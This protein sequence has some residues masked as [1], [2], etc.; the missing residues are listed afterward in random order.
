MKGPIYIVKLTKEA[1]QK[2]N[3]KKIRSEVDKILQ[4][5]LG[6]AARK[7]AWNTSVFESS[8]VQELG[9]YTI[10]RKVSFQRV[11]G[12][13]KVEE[14]QWSRVY[15][16][17]LKVATTSGRKWQV[18]SGHAPKTS[19]PEA[20]HIHIKDDVKD[21]APISLDVGKHFDHIFDRE[22]Q[23]RR[24]MAALQLAQQTNMQKRLHCLLYGDP[25]CGKSE[26]ITALGK[27]LGQEKTHYIQFDA[28]STT[29]AGAINVLLSSPYIPPILL[30]EEI[31]KTH[32][33]DQRWMLGLLDQRAEIR[34]TNFRV[35]NRAKNV[36]VLCIATCNDL[37]LFKSV[38]SGALAS[39]F[40]HK[41]MCPRPSREILYKILEREVGQIPEGNTT[42]INPTLDFASELEITDPREVISICLSGQ[43]HLL[44]GQYQE[45]Y[46]ATTDEKV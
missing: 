24:V 35:G 25:G 28:T 30:V 6:T 11:R 17:L 31:E 3:P 44:T 37:S 20:T 4:L 1:R 13:K 41:I 26:I 19:T 10:L 34:Q 38:M 46:R 21:Y 5:A 22:R 40:S 12:Q 27:M 2:P 42:W 45:D 32:P 39:R 15:N 23:I 43:N 18:T 7:R 36:K 16:R 14:S 33:N 9:V 29:Q 8:Q